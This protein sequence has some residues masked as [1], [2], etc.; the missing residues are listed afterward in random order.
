MTWFRAPPH[1]LGELMRAVGFEAN[2]P[3]DAF[4]ADRPQ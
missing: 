2:R 4:E 1:D 3:V